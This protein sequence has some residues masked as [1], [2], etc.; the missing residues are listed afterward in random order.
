MYQLV[1]LTKLYEMKLFFIDEAVFSFNTFKSKAWSSS[2]ENI[3][4]KEEKLRVKSQAFVAAISEDGGLESYMLHP[5]SFNQEQFITFLEQLATQHQ[6]EQIAIFLD[7]LAVHK[8]R[9]VM[10]AYKRLNINAIF[11]MPYSP[12]FNGIESYFSLVKAQ[13]KKLAL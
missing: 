4:V 2:N 13:Y 12:D 1:N 10:A 7:N 6:G 11:N 3:I 9:K 5:R 8:T